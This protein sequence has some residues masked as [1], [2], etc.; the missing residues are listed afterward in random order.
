MRQAFRSGGANAALLGVVAA[1]AGVS[2][3]CAR[4]ASVVVTV[5]SPTTFTG[6]A[7]LDVTLT[8]SAMQ[9]TSVQID[10]AVM[11]PTSFELLLRHGEEGDLEVCVATV[12]GTPAGGTG[13]ATTTLERGGRTNVTVTVDV[14]ATCGDMVLAATE[15]CDGTELGAEDC[16]TQGFGG[17]TLACAGDCTFDTAG[18]IP[19]NCGDGNLD[20][21]EDCDGTELGGNDCTS[22]GMGFLGGTL[23]CGPT[24]AFDTNGCLA[25]LCGNAAID[26]PEVCDGT[27][28]G[29]QTCATLVGG[30]GTLGCMADCNGFDNSGCTWCGNLVRDGTEDCEGT[31]FGGADCASLGLGFDGGMLGCTGAC[32]YDTSLC[33]TCGDSVAEPGEECD[34]TDLGGNTCASAGTFDGGT[35]AC[36]VGT[37][38]FETSMCTLCGD[39][40][41]EG[42]ESCDG[43]D[44]GGATCVSIGQG[45]TGGALACAADCS[46]DTGSCTAPMGCGNTS[47]DPGEDCDL[48]AV[49]PVSPSDTCMSVASL[50]DGTLGCTGGCLFDTSDCHDCGNQTREG[51][52]AC[53]GADL[54]GQTCVGLGHDGGTLVCQADCTGFDAAGCT[55]C[56]DG[57]IESPEACEPSDNGGATCEGLG[58]ACG[59]LACNTFCTGFDE[60][61]CISTPPSVPVPR[62]PM[63]NAYVGSIFSNASL[64]IT[65]DWQDSFSACGPTATIEYEL[66]YDTAPSFSPGAVTEV[67]PATMFTT[68]SLAASAT[69]PVG[70]RYYWHVRACLGVVCSAYSP[71]RWVNLGRDAHDENGD[72]FADVLAGAPRR[73][74]QLNG[75]SDLGSAFIYPGSASPA[76]TM[77]APLGLPQLFGP[78]PPPSAEAEFGVSVAYAGDLNADGYA[79]VIVGAWAADDA[80]ASGTAYVYLGPVST[81]D[82]PDL[83][84]TAGA[85]AGSRFGAAVGSAGDVNADGYDDFVV[86]APYADTADVDDGAAFVFF[87]GPSPDDVADV[88][89][90]A[91]AGTS[92]HF[93]TSV[94]SAGDVDGDGR[95]DVLVGAPDADN[96]GCSFGNAMGRAFVFLGGTPPDGTPDAILGEVGSSCVGNYGIALAGGDL[97]GDG[98]SEVVVCDPVFDLP[99]GGDGRCFI[100]QGGWPLSLTAIRIVSDPESAIGTERFGASV[101]FVPSLDGSALGDLVVGGPLVNGGAMDKGAVYVYVDPT[102]GVLPPGPTYTI[103]GD[104]A[105]DQLG[106]AVAAAGDVNGDGSTDIVMSAPLSD[107]TV[108]DGGRA[109]VLLGCNVV[110]GSCALNGVRDVTLDLTGLAAGDNLGWS[111]GAW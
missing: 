12:G 87:G 45:F 60:S 36:D 82:V 110:S 101:D 63:N 9:M 31:D 65:F 37:C 38:M 18:C 2:V 84:V 103:N 52:E 77:S 34:G 66:Q 32:A 81:G 95:A 80:A 1:L 39:G 26:P 58:Y 4:A 83:T 48:M 99:G 62:L 96:P 56:G 40:T 92:A 16:L 73:N 15:D 7:G 71:T 61:M 88:T 100:Y 55:D 93:G 5:E 43:T 23:A 21:G 67:T 28:L 51:P 3:S 105:N 79:D 64:A 49:P 108:M 24:C 35:L 22:V 17:G 57:V 89:L 111:V 74:G 8:D 76:L 27:D 11:L 102:A 47:I 107:A 29:A 68:A 70:T 91:G 86:G 10:Q 106:W 19:L 41:A 90:T 20:A 98:L 109:W 30:T 50:M 33:T 44:L 94:R 59:T 46:Y 54:A 104:A 78:P 25:T 85:A 13:C 53:D 6:I 97:T 14:P 72:A 69:A 42:A 75:E